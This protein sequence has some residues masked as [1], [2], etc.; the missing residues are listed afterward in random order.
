MAYRFGGTRTQS[1]Q[2]SWDNYVPEGRSGRSGRVDY[3]TPGGGPGGGLVS[4]AGLTPDDEWANTFKPKFNSKMAPASES[5]L[6]RFAKGGILGGVTD[7]VKPPSMFGSVTDSGVSIPP[8]TNPDRSMPGKPWMPK[9][10]NAQFMLPDVTQG[11]TAPARVVE[12]RNASMFKPGGANFWGASKGAGGWVAPTQ[13]QA[14]LIGNKYGG[15][16]Y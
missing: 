13:K 11:G 7:E 1:T 16:P 14:R 5:G 9:G 6:G 4:G 12:D 10:P 3:A 2:R 15:L 8:P